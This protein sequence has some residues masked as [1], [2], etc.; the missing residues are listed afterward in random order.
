ML[1]DLGTDLTNFNE[2]DL[3]IIAARQS[4][5][6]LCDQTQL[7]FEASLT[8]IIF[9][10]SVICGCP[11]PTHEAH[12]N[13]LEK[14]FSI[15]LN[16]HGYS[17]L[18]VDEVL[19]A[20]R[21]NAN[22][23]LKES[24][25][26]YN[27]IFNIVFAAKVLSQYRDRRGLIDQEAERIFNNRERDAEIE[28]EDVR[29]RKKVIAQFEQFL[30][31]ENA[32]LDLSDCFM[33]LRFDGAFANKTIPEISKSNLRGSEPV[34]KLMNSLDG[35]ETRFKKEHIAVKYLFKQMKLT[36]KLKIYDEDLK[37]CFP[38]FELPNTIELK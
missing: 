9:Q 30:S 17:G 31:D 4:G 24:V 37:L 6:S 33:Q 29:R 28:K 20:F 7:Q 27:S 23:E 19:M 16:D 21:M 3:K 11:L 34:E 35:L 36:G 12:I 8:G 2:N 32:E 1:T 26:T 25:P 38:G 14:E 18:T 5:I 22:G 10:V 13:A 15:F